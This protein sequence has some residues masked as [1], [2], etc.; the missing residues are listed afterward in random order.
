MNSQLPIRIGIRAPERSDFLQYFVEVGTTL[1]CFDVPS[2]V[3]RLHE[4]VSGL[5]MSSPVQVSA[6]SLCRAAICAIGVLL[7]AFTI[8]GSSAEAQSPNAAAILKSCGMSPPAS[9]ED[10]K[11]NSYING[12]ITGVLV[13]QV[14]REQG[15]PICFPA[16][17]NTDEVRKSVSSF[18]A[19]HPNIW[20]MDGN[21]AVGVALTDAYPCPK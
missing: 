8:A 4:P 16:R 10:Q 14:A 7:A 21:S 13:D 9:E 12:V 11:C 18:L 5:H 6:L 3:I 17:V 1:L 2:N 15:N 20:T 19:A